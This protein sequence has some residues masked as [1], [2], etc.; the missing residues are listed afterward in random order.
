MT[1]EE[2]AAL[3]AWLRRPGINWSEV[4]EQLE[5]HGSVAAA[6]AEAAPTQPT[7]FDVSSDADRAADEAGAAALTDLERWQRA[8]TRLVSVLDQDYPA[9]LRMIHQRPPVLFLRGRDDDRDARS[10]AV[11]GTRQPTSRGVE[12]AT[13]LAAGLAERGIPVISGLAAGID[14]AAHRA[15]LAAGGRTVAVIGTGIDRAY[16]AENARLQE[17]IAA[18]G[19]VISQ[20]LPGSPP[21]KFSFPMR[22]AVMSGYALATVVVEAAYRSGAKMQARLALQHGRHVFLMRG[23]LEHDWAQEY[24]QRPGVTV[25]GGAADVLMELERLAAEPTELVWT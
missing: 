9:N 6:L 17:E 19:L 16:P 11:V 7:L 21:T 14:A 10:I 12:D 15:A 20:F 23:L 13:H 18:K 22:N 24:A 1:R 2:Q 4:T 25:V 8:D 5:E 3:V